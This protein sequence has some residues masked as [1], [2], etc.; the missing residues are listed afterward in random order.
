MHPGSWL[1]F[2]SIPEAIKVLLP[3]QSHSENQLPEFSWYSI[4]YFAFSSFLFCLSYLYFFFYND[5]NLRLH[6]KEVN[7][8]FP[9]KTKK[10]EKLIN[11]AFLTLSGAGDER[12]EL[13]PKVLETP[14]IPLDQSPILQLIAECLL[15]IPY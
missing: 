8:Y 7:S 3:E 12:I 6:L 9:A 14:I 1:V 4:W 2:H 13:P 11:K 10:P 15:F 5:Y